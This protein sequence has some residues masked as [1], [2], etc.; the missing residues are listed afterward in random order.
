MKISFKALLAAT[1]VVA[2]PGM[3]LANQELLKL[4]ADPN[5]WSQQSGNYSGWRYT[6]LDQINKGNVANLGV[7]WQFSTG[8]ARP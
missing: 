4:Q 3:A 8:V 2:L 1:A 7:A 6:A 5:Q